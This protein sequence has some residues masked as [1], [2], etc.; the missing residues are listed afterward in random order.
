[1]HPRLVSSIFF[2]CSVVVAF[3][4]HPIGGGSEYF[5]STYHG[6][7]MFTN[8]QTESGEFFQWECHQLLRPFAVDSK[9]MKVLG[10]RGT[11]GRKESL[12][13]SG[14]SQVESSLRWAVLIVNPLPIC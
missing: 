12:M 9:K 14:N 7:K 5:I 8:F 10:V 3:G 13:G 4:T 1:M 2:A 11:P 6:M